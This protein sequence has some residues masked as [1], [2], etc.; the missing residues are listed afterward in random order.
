[1]NWKS[2][3]ALPVAALA[4]GWKPLSCA[5]WAMSSPKSAELAWLAWRI[6]RTMAG[7]TARGKAG[8]GLLGAAMA[9]EA[10][11]KWLIERDARA[12]QSN[13]PRRDS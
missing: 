4:S 12:K 1:M 10:R 2:P 5:A 9:H 8:F 3:A 6:W 7:S 13:Q 11:S